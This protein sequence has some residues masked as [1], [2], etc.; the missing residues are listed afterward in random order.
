VQL[1]SQAKKKDGY[2]EEIDVGT[3][4]VR[5]ADIWLKQWLVLTSGTFGDFNSMTVGWGSI[6]GMWK[7]PFALVVVRPGRHTFHYMEKYS[8][9]TLCAFPNSR[10]EALMILGT[11]S[12]RDSDKIAESGLTVVESKVVEA[13]SY[14]EA[15][16]ILECRKIYWQDMNPENFLSGD[17]EENYPLNDYHRIYYG[18]IVRASG[19][20]AYRG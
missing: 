10:K 2:M 7:R 20:A 1:L 3:L 18:E 13:P 5:S 12:G 16:L 9:F 4:Q 15:E 11:K 19:E 14:K 8:T 17:I 6:G